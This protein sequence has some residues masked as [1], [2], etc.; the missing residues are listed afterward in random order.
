MSQPVDA[1]YQSKEL[2]LYS[3]D[4]KNK[5]TFA[6]ATGL[7][8]GLAPVV[9]VL[10]LESNVSPEGYQGSIA[11]P[12]L[13][14]KLHASDYYSFLSYTLFSLE[15]TGTTLTSGLAQ[16]LV[17]RKAADATLTSG[18]AAEVKARGDADFIHTGA[19]AQE[20]YDRGLGDLAN[21]G[22]IAT[23]V[24]DRKAAITTVSA[25]AGANTLAIAAET[26]AREEADVKLTTA[27][28]DEKTRAEL[29]EYG[30]NNDIQGEIGHRMAAVSEV[31]AAVVAEAKLAREKEALL[32]A[33]IDFITHNTNP[34][35]IDSL[36]EIVSQ[37][38][39]NGQGYADRLTYL[40]Q[41]IAAL[42]AQTQS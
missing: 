15:S 33:R 41:V 26:K 16:E 32:D 10:K 21:A 3:N 8:P 7:I 13:L 28:S 12:N 6:D 11:I 2:N 18:L 35:A 34:A 30:L 38:S 19:I 20:V 17:D 24:S 14:Y 29:A 1:K 37:F 42:V 4:S 25:A 27:V 22:A 39:S 5:Y 31:S 9:P 40:E 23:E 36:S